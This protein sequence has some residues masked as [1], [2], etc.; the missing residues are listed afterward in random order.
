ME[1]SGHGEETG[2]QLLKKCS[3][4]KRKGRK[5]SGRMH[6]PADELLN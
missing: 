5:R 1:S 4:R 6:Q 3:G 2:T